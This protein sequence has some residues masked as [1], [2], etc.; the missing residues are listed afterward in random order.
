MV[1]LI[2]KKRNAKVWGGWYW[3]KGGGVFEGGGGLLMRQGDKELSADARFYVEV[4][5][6][7][8]EET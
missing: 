6:E 4:F 7:W 2:K 1:Q 5:I 8:D 3:E